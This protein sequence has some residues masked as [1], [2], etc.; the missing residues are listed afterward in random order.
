MRDSIAALEAKREAIGREIVRVG[1]MRQGS[2]NENFRVCGK[3]NCACSAGDHP[4]HGPYYA[5][6]TK[7]AGKTK[8]VQLRPGPRLEK[9]EREVEAYRRFR[10]LSQQLLEVNGAI[11]EARS[12]DPGESPER[13][14]LKKTSRGSSKKRLR[15][16]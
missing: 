12:E 4:G 9:F 13:T 3:P 11:C 1:D 14:A 10:A 16:K 7:V 5:F 15:R 6:T 8:T 2:I